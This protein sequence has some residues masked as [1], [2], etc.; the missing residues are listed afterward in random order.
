MDQ[1]CFEANFK[2][3][4]CVSSELKLIKCCTS[5]ATEMDSQNFGKNNIW[6][7]FDL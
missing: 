4:G 5:L 2:L 1:M 7:K 3:K 6:A